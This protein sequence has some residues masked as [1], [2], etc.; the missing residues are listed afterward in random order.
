MAKHFFI[1][2]GRDPRVLLAD[3]V[4]RN[5]GA[6][7]YVVFPKVEVVYEALGGTLEAGT[8]RCVNFLG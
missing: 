2:V 8:L 6:N 7:I 5:L 1:A 3:A 4:N